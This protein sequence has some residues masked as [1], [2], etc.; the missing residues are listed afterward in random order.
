M[1]FG[2]RRPRW[3]GRLLCRKFLQHIK[4]RVV[5]DVLATPTCP[6]TIPGVGSPFSS[7]FSYTPAI[8]AHFRLGFGVLGEFSGWSGTGVEQL[9]ASVLFIGGVPS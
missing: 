9:Y 3:R 4:D 5:D 6:T 2:F 8:S 7:F 1:N